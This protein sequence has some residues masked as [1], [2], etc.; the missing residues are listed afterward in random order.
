M[1]GVGQ[2]GTQIVGNLPGKPPTPVCGLT[3]KLV[4]QLC[5]NPTGTEPNGAGH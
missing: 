5:S 4:Q 3:P 1:V 2:G